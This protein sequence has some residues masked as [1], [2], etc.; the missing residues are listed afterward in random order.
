[1][2]VS[3]KEQEFAR[4][5]EIN[6]GLDFCDSGCLGREE[7]WEDINEQMDLAKFDYRLKPEPLTAYV[8]F[9]SIQDS[10]GRRYW[11]AYCRLE[12]AEEDALDRGFCGLRIV[13][14]RDE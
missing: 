8:A 2:A 6:G 5:E 4:W 3:R 1:M 10:F 7:Q 11:H 9:Y 14:V 12:D 13:E